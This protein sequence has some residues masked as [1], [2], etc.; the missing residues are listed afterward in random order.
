VT[1]IA[2]TEETQWLNAK[3]RSSLENRFQ[4]ERPV[5]VAA[6]EV[7]SL[8]FRQMRVVPSEPMAVSSAQVKQKLEEFRLEEDEVKS[9]IAVVRT[10]Q[11]RRI[12]SVIGGPVV[13]VRSQSEGSP[14]LRE[15]RTENRVVI[16]ETASPSRS[17]A[18]HSEGQEGKAKE[19]HPSSSEKSNQPKEAASLSV[20]ETHGADYSR[21]PGVTPEQQ[22]E[23][24]SRVVRKVAGDGPVTEEMVSPDEDL[25]FKTLENGD[26]SVRSPSEFKVRA[27]RH[28]SGRIKKKA[29]STDEE[30]KR[31]LEELSKIGAE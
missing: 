2:E 1:Y 27:V 20:P 12:A 18:S 23:V 28:S 25:S 4:D 16:Q 21:H 13:P 10:R 15:S 6:G 9:A 29:V 5:Q 14:T 31:I 22:E 17:P 11:D 8:N 26:R 24:R 19:V 7:S 3:G 30:K